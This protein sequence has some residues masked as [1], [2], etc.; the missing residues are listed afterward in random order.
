MYRL[1]LF[2]RRIYVFVIFLVLEGFAL[3]FYAN[4]TV[5]SRARMLGVS[6]RVIGGIY[7]GIAGAERYMS[8][9]KTN[10][11]LEGRVQS[12]ENELAAYRERCSMAQLDSIIAGV[13]F[14]HEYVVA[15]VVRNS[16]D[17]RENYIMVD[18]GTR[19]GVE[20]G[21]AVVSLDGFMVGYVESCSEKN[22]ICVSALNMAFRA[23][24]MVAHTGHFGSI[25][26]QGGDPRKVRLSEVP[27]YA[28]IARGDTILTSSYSFYF[29]EGIHIGTVEGFETDEA[30][31]S[32]NIDVRLGVDIAALRVV[33]LVKN[34]EAYE[35]IKLEEEVLGTVEQ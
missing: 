31:A 23:S 24:G 21:M 19:D 25:S 32:Y 29:P 14:P 10:R 1:L 4:S 7:S 35:R 13:E 8:L 33:M 11:L 16:V 18:R 17:K 30:T 26:W 9:G 15:R 34:P 6:D 27:K 3:H 12:L 22:S 28:E 5:H 2:L 20:R